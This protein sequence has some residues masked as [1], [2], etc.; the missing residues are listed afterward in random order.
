MLVRSFISVSH[1]ELS[2]RV[3][4]SRCERKWHATSTATNGPG[5]GHTRCIV[6]WLISIV[7]TGTYVRKYI[8]KTWITTRELRL[9]ILGTLWLEVNV[10]ISECES[11]LCLKLYTQVGLN[12][13]N[14]VF[15]HQSIRISYKIFSWC[16]M[17]ISGAAIARYL[18]CYFYEKAIR[19]FILISTSTIFTLN[20]CVKYTHNMYFF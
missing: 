6:S 12:Y 17:T 4:S 16:R 2:L 15:I 9:L 20:F 5:P 10:N 19:S 18:Y 11:T 13:N 14:S 7:C 1:L 3:S 8:C